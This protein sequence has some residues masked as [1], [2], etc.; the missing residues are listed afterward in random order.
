MFKKKS[1]WFL[2]VVVAG[3]SWLWYSRRDAGQPQYVTAQVVRGDV[4]Q[5]VSAS[6]TLVADGEVD[7]N[8]ETS[9][10]IR[11]VAVKVGDTV[12]QGDVLAD[13]EAVALDEEVKKA[14]AAVAKAEADAGVNDD[15]LREARSAA[16][17]AKDLLDQTEDAE[18]RKAEASKKSLSNAK[19]YEDD[20]K[21]Y[22][23]QVAS[24]EGAGSAAAKS[25]KLTLTRAANDRKEAERYK[26]TVE[27]SRDVA[28]QNAK[29]ALDA[30]RERVKTLES[31]HRQTIENS[32]IQT[33]RSN[34]E[35]AL[36]NLQ[37][38]RLKAPVNG[39]VTKLNFQRGEVVGSAVTQPFGRLLSSDLILEADVPESDIAQIRLNETARV[40]FDALNQDEEFE[41]TVVEIEPEST[42]VQDVVYYKAKL[43]LANI[44]QRLKPGMSADIDVRV[45]DKRGVLVL[46]SRA[47]RQENG[48]RYLEVLSADGKTVERRDVRVGLEGDEGRTEAVSGVREGETVVTEK[49]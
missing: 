20:A 33:A 9:G 46:P 45:A 8:F 6:A 18:D 7:L 41:A 44:D 40:T 27:A 2:I 5:T 37:K 35:I 31:K 29:N 1:F 38:A 4:V 14:Q 30:A 28:V 17:N 19:E 23:D 39:T 32:A 49:K 24:D 10:R 48:G 21:A 42:V 12:G 16:D 36:D 15:E 25:A 47:I 26:E 22:Y 3:G 11:D 43:R 34:Y 13:L